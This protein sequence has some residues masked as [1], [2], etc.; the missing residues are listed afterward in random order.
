MPDIG[1]SWWGDRSGRGGAAR[2]PV[3]RR[4][5]DD[6][7][8]EGSHG[9]DRGEI[10]QKL[11]DRINASTRLTAAQKDRIVEHVNASR[12]R[13]RSYKPPRPAS[14]G[15]QASAYPLSQ[16]ASK[17]DPKDTGDFYGGMLS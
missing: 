12:R 7:K 3:F 8:G 13:G 5:D 11:I 17:L 4:D 6:T 9:L 10:K 15:V 16:A 1:N 2:P 14:M